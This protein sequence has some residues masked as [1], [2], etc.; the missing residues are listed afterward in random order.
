MA[1]PPSKTPF[2]CINLI[3]AEENT[4]ISIR[5]SNE[6]KNTETQIPIEI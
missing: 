5:N 4:E 2:P 1:P 6:Q 3:E